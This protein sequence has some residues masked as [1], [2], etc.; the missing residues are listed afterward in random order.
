MVCAKG[1]TENLV[2]HF[3]QFEEEKLDIFLESTGTDER[4]CSQILEDAS[5]VILKF[6][7]NRFA[8]LVW[9]RRGAI[10]SDDEPISEAFSMTDLLL[11]YFLLD[12]NV[13]AATL[14][15]IMY[16]CF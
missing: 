2:C 6:E 7:L 4:N 3:H 12:N 13:N 11:N 9:H 15:S 16:L 14:L 8:P 5:K 1:P 10:D